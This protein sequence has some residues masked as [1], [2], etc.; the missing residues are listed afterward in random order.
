MKESIRI[1]NYTD[2]ENTH[3]NFL[4]DNMIFTQEIGLKVN[5]KA[6][7]HIYTITK[8]YSVV[9]GKMIKKKAK[10]K[11]TIL[12]GINLL[13][14]L[15]IIKNMVWENIICRIKYINSYGIMEY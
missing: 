13:E 5:V 14:T 2:K 3:I 10:E 15:K 6:K 9:T 1:I 7:E 8:I 4:V 12:M 11:C